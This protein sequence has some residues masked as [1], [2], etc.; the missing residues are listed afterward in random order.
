MS[1]L[2]SLVHYSQLSHRDGPLALHSYHLHRN[3]KVKTPNLLQYF[4]L[5]LDLGERHVNIASS[6][7]TT[8]TTAHQ[9]IK[10]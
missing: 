3:D 7:T 8:G 2:S 1:K 6:L 9:Y 4:G 10:F 5:L